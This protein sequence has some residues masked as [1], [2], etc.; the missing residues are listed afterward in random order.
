LTKIDAGAELE[1]LAA[2]ARPRGGE[3][4]DRGGVAGRLQQECALIAEVIAALDRLGFRCADLC[5]VHRNARNF[6]L[7][8]DLLFVRPA[9]FAK[10]GE[11]AGIV[12]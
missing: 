1:V 11:A 2:R 9:L 12:P 8:L 5:E 10:Y 4:P 3:R 6:V 7:Q